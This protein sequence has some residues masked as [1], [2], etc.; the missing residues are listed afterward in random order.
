MREKTSQG[1]GAVKSNHVTHGTELRR[2]KETFS[3]DML[4]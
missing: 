2:S 3:L 1:Y 4:F